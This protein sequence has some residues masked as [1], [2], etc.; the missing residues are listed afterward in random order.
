MVAGTGCGDARAVARRGLLSAVC[1]TPA[2]AFPAPTTFPLFPTT[3]AMSTKHWLMKAEPDSRIV[4]GKDVK[5]R[6]TPHSTRVSMSKPGGPRQF[7]VDDF[8][9]CGTTPWEGVRNFEARNL[10]KEMKVG[11]KVSVSPAQWPRL[12]KSVAESTRSFL[13]VLFY[14]SNC[15]N[16]GEHPIKSLPI[17]DVSV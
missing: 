8:E 13:Q 15:K 10:M 2:P 3:P 16:P 17:L 12:V 11:D 9:A 5:V 14:H 4:K 7:S 6:P 1:A